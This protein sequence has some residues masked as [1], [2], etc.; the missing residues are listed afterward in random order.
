VPQRRV[1][2]RQEESA[3]V[4]EAR[5]RECATL[6]A[7]TPDQM[8]EWFAPEQPGQMVLLPLAISPRRARQVS[9][10]Q[11]RAAP[12]VF[13]QAGPRERLASVVAK[14]EKALAASPSFA[15]AQVASPK[16]E[17]TSA[18]AVLRKP[19]S[20]PVSLGQVFLL[21]GEPREPEAA[22]QVR[23]RRARPRGERKQAGS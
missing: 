13:V 12:A 3:L 8:A 11:A 14:R 16:L 20:P 15:A 21:Q 6:A 2:T 9:A 7:G 18:L 10:Q 5:A 1:L 22:A 4:R 17:T 23:L 19:E